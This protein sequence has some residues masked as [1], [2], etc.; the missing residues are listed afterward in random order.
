MLR[1][2]LADVPI[3]ENEKNM[4][5]NS[6]NENENFGKKYKQNQTNCL[7]LSSVK[8]FRKSNEIK[9]VISKFYFQRWLYI[10]TKM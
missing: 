7:I 2:D 9:N 5:G 8:L 10:T 1:E 3:L 4:F 6:H